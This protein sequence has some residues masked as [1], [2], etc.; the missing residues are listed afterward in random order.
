[1]SEIDKLRRIILET[2]DE[3]EDAHEKI[4][5]MGERIDDLRGKIYDY[6][7]DIMIAKR[8]LKELEDEKQRRRDS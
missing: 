2:E 3:I 7:V 6:Q 5:R 1:M 8:R 4:H